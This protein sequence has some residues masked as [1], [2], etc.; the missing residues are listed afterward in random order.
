MGRLQRILYVFLTQ[1]ESCRRGFNF[2][3]KRELFAL[4]F[5]WMN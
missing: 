2:S 1:Q 4:I 5:W 3:V